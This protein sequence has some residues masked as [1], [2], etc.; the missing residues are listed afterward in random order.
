[1]SP[2]WGIWR[3]GS[4]SGRIGVG[5]HPSDIRYPHYTESV[6]TPWWAMVTLKVIKDALL[7]RNRHQS[8]PRW[9]TLSCL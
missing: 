2:G 4:V 5:P 8:G 7:R 1:L 6:N 3:A 9:S